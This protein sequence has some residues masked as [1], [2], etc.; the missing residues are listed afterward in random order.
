MS[1]G[2]VLISNHMH[3]IPH[4]QTTE[5]F[6]QDD[7]GLIASADGRENYITRNNLLNADFNKLQA[8]TSVRFVEEMGDKGPQASSVQVE[9]KHQVV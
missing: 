6:P 7:Y 1:G 9:G 3:R 5:L 8:G 2:G 4:G